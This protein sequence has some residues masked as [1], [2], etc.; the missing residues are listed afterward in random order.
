MLYLRSSA[1]LKSEK[2]SFH[3]YYEGNTYETVSKETEHLPRRLLYLAHCAT[4]V[5]P[6]GA[7][8]AGQAAQFQEDEGVLAYSVVRSLWQEQKNE[9]IPKQERYMVVQHV[10]AAQEDA[11]GMDCALLAREGSFYF[12]CLGR[13]EDVLSQCTTQRVGEESVPLVPQERDKILSL[14]TSLT[15]QGIVV[16]AVGFRSS[17]YNSLRR[18]SVLKLM[19]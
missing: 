12:T 13:V 18:I 5:A 3:A 2:I 14:A 8:T 1:A 15:M 17:H 6:D 11:S 10:P 19:L 7:V 4:G 16:A 9:K